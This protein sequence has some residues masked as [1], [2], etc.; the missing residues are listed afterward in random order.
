MNRVISRARWAHDG[1]E[2]AAVM[3]WYGGGWAWW[4]AGVMWVGMLLFWGALVAVVFVLA[5][6]HL[7]AYAVV[8]CIPLRP[9]LC[10]SGQLHGMVRGPVARAR[11]ASRAVAVPVPVRA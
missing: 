7:R 11:N 9:G 5:H 4:Q 2:V 6:G 8:A 10:R 1:L 3:F